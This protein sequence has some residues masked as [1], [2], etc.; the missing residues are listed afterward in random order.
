[1]RYDK[2]VRD[3]IPEIIGSRGG[4]PLTHTA[5]ETEYWDKLK[6]KLSEEVAEFH[7]DE[8]EE[9]MADILE[10]I[11]AIYAYKNFDT[12]AILA[13]KRKKLEERG[14]FSKRIILEES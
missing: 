5:D 8:N 11:D 7:A 12:Q 14:G 4:N 2:L 1:M 13:I 9:E 6:A 3:K 10:V